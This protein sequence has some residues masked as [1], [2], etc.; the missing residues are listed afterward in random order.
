MNPIWIDRP[1]TWTPTTAEYYATTSAIGS[2]ALKRFHDSPERFF[3]YMH[4]MATI[5]CMGPASDSEQ[6]SKV[7]ALGSAVDC[8]LTD[9][10]EFSRRFVV[11]DNKGIGVHGVTKLPSK[12]YGKVRRIVMA[13]QQNPRAADLLSRPKLRQMCHKWAVDGLD[14]RLRA[15]YLTVW[16]DGVPVVV[17]L[18]VWGV[19]ISRD[20]QVRQHAERLGAFLQL[21]LYGQGIENLWGVFPHLVLI[22]ASS[23]SENVRVDQLDGDLL[24]KSIAEVDADQAGLTECFR[25]WDFSTEQQQEFGS[26]GT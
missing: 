4:E 5:A 1:P 12:L 3:W 24:D 8:L 26:F 17:D 7:M 6:P 16:V 11:T 19:D 25:T 13:I 2:G 9:P 21:A 18:K 20:W 23:K 10:R 14:Y 15:D 22:I